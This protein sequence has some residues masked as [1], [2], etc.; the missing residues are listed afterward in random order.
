MTEH[1]VVGEIKRLLAEGLHQKALIAGSHYAIE[2]LRRAATLSTQTENVIWA[3]VPKYGLPSLIPKGEDKGT[4]G[5][6]SELLESVISKQSS[7]N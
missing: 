2:Q 5:E 3:N 4:T 6:I 1:E 7:R